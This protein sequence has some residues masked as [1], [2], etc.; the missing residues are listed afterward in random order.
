MSKILMLIDDATEALHTF[1]AYYR[2][3]EDDFEVVVAGP[4]TR[5]YHTML[6]EIPTCPGTSLRSR[7]VTIFRQT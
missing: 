6:H 2:L 5:L 7:P 4:E 1:Y 3:P